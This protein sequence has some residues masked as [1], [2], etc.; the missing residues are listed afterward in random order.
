MASFN[1][2]EYN[3]AYYLLYDEIYVKQRLIGCGLYEVLSRYLF[4]ILSN[5]VFEDYN[6]IDGKYSFATYQIEEIKQLLKYGDVQNNVEAYVSDNPDI[7]VKELFLLDPIRI[8][9]NCNAVV[10]DRMKNNSNVSFS[11]NF[12]NS[13]SSNFKIR[14]HNQVEAEKNEWKV[15]FTDKELLGDDIFL[16]GTLNTNYIEFNNETQIQGSKTYVLDFDPIEKDKKGIWSLGITGL[17][18]LLFLGL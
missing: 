14:W 9:E 3:Q 7:M 10:Y 6:I 15:S 4:A 5:C 8:D 2:Q 11:D 17:V 12:I 18:T 13:Q 16:F 1:M